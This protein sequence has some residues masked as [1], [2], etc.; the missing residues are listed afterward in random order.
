MNYVP[1]KF[2]ETCD[3][4]TSLCLCSRIVPTPDGHASEW[5]YVAYKEFM[6]RTRD[7]ELQEC[8]IFLAGIEAGIQSERK[9]GEELVKALR[10]ESAANYKAAES[11]KEAALKQQE[12][13]DDKAAAL[14]SRCERLEKALIVAKRSVESYAGLTGKAQPREALAVIDAALAPPADEEK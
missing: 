14:T 10:E 9:R 5:E 3:N 12:M 8:E 1:P 2:C 13:G 7:V 6:V 4:P 11:W